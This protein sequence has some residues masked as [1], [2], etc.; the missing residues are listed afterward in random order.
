MKRYFS[1]EDFI[2]F[3]NLLEENKVTEL[4]TESVEDGS[5]SKYIFMKIKFSG[6]IIILYDHPMCQVGIIQDSP[7]APWDDYAEGVYEDFTMKDEYKMFIK[8]E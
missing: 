8:T 5:I 6:N 7:V 3:L 2:T 1:L 4:F